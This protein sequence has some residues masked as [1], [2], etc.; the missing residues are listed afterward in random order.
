MLIACEIIQAQVIRMSTSSQCF[1]QIRARE[2][3]ELY[4]IINYVC[5]IGLKNREIP[6]IMNAGMSKTHNQKT[7][8]R[9]KVD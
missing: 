5:K 9:A 4:F 3:T 2:A 8:S 7:R 1:P 6:S